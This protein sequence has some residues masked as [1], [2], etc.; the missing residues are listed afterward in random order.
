[1]A[2]NG[3]VDGSARAVQ[4]LNQDAAPEIAQRPNINV[5]LDVN[6]NLQRFLNPHLHAEDQHLRSPQ[7]PTPLSENESRMRMTSILSSIGLDML[8]KQ[9]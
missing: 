3:Q 2:N 6:Y 4:Y 1:M 8:P 9:K 5:P 7:Y